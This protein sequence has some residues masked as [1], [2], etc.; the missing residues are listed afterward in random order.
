VYLSGITAFA[1]PLLRQPSHVGEIVAALFLRS[2][3]E[4]IL[5]WLLNHQ[6]VTGIEGND[7]GLG[8]ARVWRYDPDQIQIDGELLLI[9]Q[10]HEKF[11]HA[12]GAP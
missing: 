12:V 2:S 11:W 8:I 6:R 1:A 7:R 4:Q 10:C 5:D 9:R 3:I